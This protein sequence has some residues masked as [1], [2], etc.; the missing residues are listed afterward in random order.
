MLMAIRVDEV[1][2][3]LLLRCYLE[4]PAL[5]TFTNQGVAVRQPLRAGYIFAEEAFLWFRR[6]FPLNLFGHWIQL[7]H[8]RVSSKRTIVEDKDVPVL[9]HMRLMLAIK[10]AWSP[11]PHNLAVLTVDHGYDITTPVRDEYVARF[12]YRL[13]TIGL[14]FFPCCV[15]ADD[16]AG[17]IVSPVER[18]LSVCTT[19]DMTP[20]LAGQQVLKFSDLFFPAPLPNEFLVTGSFDQVWLR[21]ERR[22]PAAVPSP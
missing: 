8:S 4:Q 16:L 1:P 6:I 20:S 13:G 22:P 3:D 17:V 7:N 10:Y 18:K 5:T 2:D 19:H 15:R 11:C 21:C 14:L 9:E 12:E